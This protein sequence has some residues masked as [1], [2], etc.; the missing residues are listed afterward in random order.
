MWIGTQKVFLFGS[1]DLGGALHF[2][3]FVS[4]TFRLDMIGVKMNKMYWESWC[5]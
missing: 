4:M 5:G 1:C 3:L 2:A